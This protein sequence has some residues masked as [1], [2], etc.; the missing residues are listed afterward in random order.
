MEDLIVRH[1]GTVRNSTE[2]IIQFI[3]GE[4]SFD[5]CSLEPQGFDGLHRPE[6]F[7]WTEEELSEQFLN[8]KKG[9]PGMKMEQFIQFVNVEQEQLRED[10]IWLSQFFDQKRDKIV[11]T[12]VNFDR[13]L[14]RIKY[15]DLTAEDPDGIYNFDKEFMLNPM[16]ISAQIEVLKMNLFTFNLPSG[17]R[18][19]MENKMLSRLLRDKLASKR[20]LY[21]YKLSLHQFHTLLEHVR[22]IYLTSLVDPGE[23]VGTIAA[24]SIG[25]PAQQMTLNS[26]LIHRF[27]YSIN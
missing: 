20:V 13:L 26:K 6:I 9:F 22:N 3:Y 17:K 1:D 14:K 7:D 10:H 23:M 8:A 21:E 11:L 5:P 19:Y 24:Q 16:Y 15:G 2:Q 27:T 18:D 4:D 25:E 12:P